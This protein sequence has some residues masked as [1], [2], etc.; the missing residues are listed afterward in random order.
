[1]A[2][3]TDAEKELIKKFRENVSDALESSPEKGDPFLLRWIR[4]RDH[5]L[6]KAEGMLRN[7]L[8]WRESMGA[9]KVLSHPPDP[10]FSSTYPFW[11]EGR[12]KAGLPLIEIVIGGWD[13]RLAVNDPDKEVPLEQHVITFFEGILQAI[14]NS[15]KDSEIIP[16]D[17]QNEKGQNTD[18]VWPN[19]V[20]SLIVDWRGYSYSQLMHWKALQSTLKMAATY[21]AHY[22][23]I[24]HKIWF[25]NC[26]SIFPLFM[27]LLKPILAPRTLAKISCLGGEEAWGPALR[28]EIDA[29]SLAHLYGGEREL[30]VDGK[31]YNYPK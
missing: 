1:M 31:V 12:T 3:P 19:T 30:R 6:E 26:P 17:G 7:S 5:D 10:W 16:R 21:E 11:V 20:A 13:F 4:A 15:N 25:I 28:E 27:A 29:T 14:R 23:E 9:D 22:P 18:K 8:K 24:M 2:V